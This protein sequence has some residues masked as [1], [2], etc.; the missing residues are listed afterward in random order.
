[1][2]DLPRL[3]PH[4]SGP[5]PR[6]WRVWWALARP[7]SLTASVVPVL[8]GT[9]VAVAI[10]GGLPAPDLF[11]AML[12]ASV[13]I[14]V[15]TNMFNEYYDF[16]HGLDTPQTVGIAGAIVRG[17]VPP[18][19]VLRGAIACFALALALGLYIVSRT[20]YEVLV[21]GLLSALA[22][23][24]YT[25][26]P[27]PIAYTPFG[28]LEVFVFM[29]PVIVG[30]ASFIQLG[31]WTS[32]ALLAS[33]PIACLVAAILLANNLRDVVADAR[34]GRRTIPVVLGRSA[35]LGIYAALFG[36]A[37]GSTI[38]G[39]GVGSLPLSALLSLLTAPMPLRLVRLYRSTEDPQR[40]NAGVRGSAALHARFGLLFAAGIALG[41]LLGW[42]SPAF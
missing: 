23:Y 28:E 35:G 39:I 17:L 33:L 30:L 42:R 19:H 34:A 21:L 14:Q 31:R 20:S 25:G 6:G 4:A 27:R 36:G 1:M 7:F 32:S 29:G 26:G 18:S 10:V 22:G 41:P 15:A 16:Q 37:F 8:V 24:L 11:L 2:A 38:A 13:L 9:A 5:A 12:V 40:L 3:T